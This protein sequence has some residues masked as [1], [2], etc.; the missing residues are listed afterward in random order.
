MGVI[1]T[2]LLLFLKGPLFFYN[3]SC[4]DSETTGQAKEDPGEGPLSVTP[5][6]AKPARKPNRLKK[7]INVCHQIKVQSK[8]QK[9]PPMLGTLSVRNRSTSRLP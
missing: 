3:I 2:A 4:L 8:V 1:E 5:D 9:N 7:K 6:A